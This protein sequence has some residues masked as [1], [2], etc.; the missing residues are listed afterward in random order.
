[1]NNVRGSVYI[2]LIVLLIIIGSCKKPEP[3]YDGMPLS[4]WIEELYYYDE[5]RQLTAI[6]VIAYMKTDALSAENDLR[7]MV[8]GKLQEIPCSP[9]VQKAAE[10]ALRLIGSDV[11]PIDTTKRKAKL[12]E[13]S[14]ALGDH[15][16]SVA[17]KVAAPPPDMSDSASVPLDYWMSELYTDNAAR[18][19]E[20]IRVI[21]AIGP[22]ANRAS[23]ILAEMKKGMLKDI[24]IP[25][26]IQ[27]AAAQALE[28]IKLPPH[29]AL[30]GTQVS[31]PDRSID[32]FFAFLDSLAAVMKAGYYGDPRSPTDILLDSARMLSWLGDK[33]GAIEILNNMLRIDTLSAQSKGKVEYLMERINAGK[34]EISVKP[35]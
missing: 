26:P 10:R 14:Q 28:L 24:P 23:G 7:Q 16:R 33:P 21:G 19:L 1:M 12:Q 4:Y 35:E 20:V 22:P 15:S 6:E 9:A 34:E 32:N 13:W 25:E 29:M 27:L 30:D 11:P 8:Q 5:D 2:P 31:L 3:T 18:Q 17:D